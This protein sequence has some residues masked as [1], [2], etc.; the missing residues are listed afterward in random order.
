[1]NNVQY[2]NIRYSC[3][4]FIGARIFSKNGWRYIC[5]YERQTFNIATRHNIV[6]LQQQITCM[7]KGEK[8]TQN[9][10]FTVRS[11]IIVAK[12]NKFYTCIFDIIFFRNSERI[13]IA[14]M[15][16]NWFF[17]LACTN[18]LFV[19]VWLRVIF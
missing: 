18:A 4:L 17:R 5:F 3:S 6:H 12:N 1:M 11:A 19:E 9:E 15:A 7:K 10:T 2:Y 8:N 16:I 14:Q 13:N